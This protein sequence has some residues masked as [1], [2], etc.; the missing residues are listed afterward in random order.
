[1]VLAQRL[2]MTI[3]RPLV[4]LL[5]LLV[6][7]LVPLHASKIAIPKPFLTPSIEFPDGVA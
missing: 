2:L 1:M 4:H 7:D 5:C 6:L 3:K